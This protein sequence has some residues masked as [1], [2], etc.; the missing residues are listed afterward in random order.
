M[1]L[2]GKLFARGYEQYEWLPESWVGFPDHKQLAKIFEHVG[3]ENVEAYP[4]TGGVAAVHIGCKLLD[5]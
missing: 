4:L 1:A 3:M 2:V 5:R